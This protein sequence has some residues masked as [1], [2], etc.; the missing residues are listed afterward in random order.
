MSWQVGKRQTWTC[1]SVFPCPPRVLR[2]KGKVWC[3]SDCH[4]KPISAESG[5]KKSHIADNC[6][7]HIDLMC[8]LCSQRL[9]ISV[10]AIQ[11]TSSLLFTCS[12]LAS[13]VTLK[14]QKLDPSSSKPSVQN[15]LLWLN[16]NLPYI[17]SFITDTTKNKQTKTALE[18][19]IQGGSSPVCTTHTGIEEKQ[20]KHAH[21]R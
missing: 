20:S 14:S 16:G 7:T 10:G 6:A 8:Y 15:F 18:I 5:C 9:F 12:S 1:L 4:L 21:I 17:V 11:Q 3:S 2:C 13:L 19:E